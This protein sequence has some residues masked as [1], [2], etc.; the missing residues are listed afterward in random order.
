LKDFKLGGI[1]EYK[2]IPMCEGFKMKTRYITINKLLMAV[3][4]S[5]NK[6]S[7]LLL[8]SLIGNISDEEIERFIELF[9]KDVINEYFFNK[10]KAFQKEYNT[11]DVED[12]NVHYVGET[13]GIKFVEYKD[14]Y[15]KF[16]EGS[17]KV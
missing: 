1:M 6:E 12:H 11:L 15:E 9:F 8:H 10:L 16:L 3:I 17:V 5:S 4:T 14:D 13:E 2:Q 7:D